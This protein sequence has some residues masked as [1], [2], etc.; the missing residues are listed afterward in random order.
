MKQYLIII[1]TLG[2]AF[3]NQ[4]LI[5]SKPKNF[6]LKE[7]I[8]YGLENNVTIKNADTDIEIAKKKITET[9][10]IGLPQ[11]NAKLSNTNYAKTA[12]TLM[13]DFISPIV[14]QVNKTNYGLTP[15]IPLGGPAKFPVS[16]GTKYN[17]TAELTISQLLFDGSYLV[18]LKA[19]K[20]YLEQSIVQSEKSRIKIKEA[21]SNAYF[22]VLTTKENEKILEN[23]MNTLKSI[24]TDTRELYKQ[25]FIEDTEV[26]QIE[27]MIS[28][29]ETN[30]IY[31]SNQIRLSESYLKV[32]LGMEVNKNINLT[33]DLDHL[34]ADIKDAGILSHNFSFAKNIDYRILGNQ[35]DLSTLNL[36][37]QNAAYLPKLSAFF[38]AQQNAM[39]DKWNF[40]SGSE[41]W[42]PTT[43]YGFE[44]NIPIFSSGSRKSKVKQAR[45]ELKKIAASQDEL[46]NTLNT[47]E[48]NAKISFKNALQIHLNK[49]KST[50]IANKIYKKTQIKFK[51]GISSS[52]ELEQAYS[53][54]LESEGKYIASILDLVKAKLSLSKLLSE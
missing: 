21:I 32:L 38:T 23:T 51:E 29:L 4:Q 50:A 17:A 22:L 28:E 1:I 36:K 37:N 2:F 40:F 20:A 30:L 44:L 45:L 8:E 13:P 18:G 5:G 53:Q 25:G 39:R 12:T 34:L 16:F 10:A 14:D 49:K 35:K 26:D 7:A 43:L 33:D 54:Y 41:K 27:L 48:D 24:E 31:V 46:K 15:T 47:S 19:A 9:T 52:L 11:I 3:S 42:Y 6:S